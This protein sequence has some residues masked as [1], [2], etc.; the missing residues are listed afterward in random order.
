MS[1]KAESLPPIPE[2]TRRVA[3]AAYPKGSLVMRM[4]EQLGAIF[5]DT[6]FAGLFAKRGQPA[7]A[8]WRLALVTIWQHLE[9][10]TDR[11]AADAVR[12][13]LDWK[14]A[15]SLPLEDAGF[16]HSVL[17][18]FR[19]RLVNHGAEEMLLERVLAVCQKQG[20]L[21]RGGTQRTDSTHVLA[22]VRALSH[23]EKV[24]ETLR[25]ALNDLAQVAPDWLRQQSSPD[26]FDRYSHRVENYRLPK[27]E[28]ARRDMAEVIGADGQQLLAV[29]QRADAPPQT[30]HLASVEVLRQVWAQHY[31]LSEGKLYWQAPLPLP[32]RAV[33]A[34][35]YDADA[36]VGKKRE[37]QWTGYKVHVT[38]TCDPEAAVHLIIGVE[39]TPAPVS[40]VERTPAVHEQMQ[41]RDLAPAV[42]LVDSGYVSA[43]VL[44][45]G[46]KQGIEVV[47]PVAADSSW[48]A[49][50]KQ[51]YAL[52]DFTIEWEQEQARCP[53]GQVSQR[54]HVSHAD[55]H[56][57]LVITF[58]RSTCLAC[59]MHAQCSQRQD[60]GRQLRIQPPAAQQALEQ[61]R[62]EQTTPTFQRQYAQR[63]GI[64]GTLA[65]G[66]RAMGLRRSRY[67]GLPKTHVQHVAIACAINL[68]RIDALCLASPRA[69]T[70]RSP[71]A[72][73]RDDIAA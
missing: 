54:W 58:A 4:R 15:L 70:R 41:Q 14:Y 47:G 44:L 42:H 1:L 60:K 53:Q 49:H 2:E 25:A 69:G 62:Q 27:G 10:L 36:R 56:E 23:L 45:S 32:D 30:Q 34:S 57:Q 28:Q 71:F 35:P 37:T 17:T 7:E 43:A 8:P 29:L 11:Q 63:A 61:R 38:E 72:Q 24:G 33:I 39:T 40:D 66:V 73:L 9:N 21:S 46:R 5:T 48:Q 18:E 12:G 20:W 64:E 16:D 6:D 67:R 13:R 22:A 51:G 55:G 52:S 50:A 26:W 31:R 3:Q 59:P 19:A 68:V 65:H